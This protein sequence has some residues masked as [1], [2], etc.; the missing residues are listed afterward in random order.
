MPDRFLPLL[1]IFAIIAGAAAAIV[2]PQ[3]FDGSS[4]ARNNEYFVFLETMTERN[5]TLIESTNRLIT[6][7][8]RMVSEHERWNCQGARVNWKY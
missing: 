1:L 5:C 3:I 6:K 8:Q 4:R 7:D 2:I